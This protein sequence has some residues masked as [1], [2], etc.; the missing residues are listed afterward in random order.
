MGDKGLT[1]RPH[2]DPEVFIL[3]EKTKRQT[4]FSFM[5]ADVDFVFNIK[6]LV[7]NKTQKEI[8]NQSTYMYEDE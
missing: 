5:K 7:L 3:Q 8:D 2:H 1:R 4:L 6:S